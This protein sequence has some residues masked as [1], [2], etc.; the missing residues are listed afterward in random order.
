MVEEAKRQQ[1]I[2]KDVA[3]KIKKAIQKTNAPFDIA[4]NAVPWGGG[5]EIVISD[6]N[7]YD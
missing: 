1:K 7:V 5:Q 4:A 2:I 3:A 6:T